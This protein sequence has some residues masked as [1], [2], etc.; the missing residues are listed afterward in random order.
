M[1]I[2][3]LFLIIIG[4]TLEINANFNKEKNNSYTFSVTSDFIWAKRAGGTLDDY[5]Y[6][7]SVDGNR[8]TYVTGRFIGTSDFGKTYLT[9][10]PED[11]YDIFVAKLD[12][13]RNWL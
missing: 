9:S 3:L 10:Q 8:N 11:D 4:L 1:V 13:D 5:G 6:G 12:I 2:T 7:I